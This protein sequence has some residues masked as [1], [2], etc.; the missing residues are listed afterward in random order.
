[1]G[2]MKQTSSDR[3]KFFVSGVCCAAEE[4][5]VR[6]RLDSLIGDESYTFNSITC[7]L[8]LPASVDEYKV[9][10]HLRGAGFVTRRKEDLQEEA[11]FWQRHTDAITTVAATILAGLGLVL[12]QLDG[13]GTVSNSLLLVAIMVG[14]WK[15]FIKAFKAAKSFSLDMNF[16]MTIAVL[17][18]ILIGKWG[19]GAAV[20]VL[21]ALSLALESYSAS[22]TR[23]AIQSLMKLSPSQAS[24][25][26]DGKEKI[27][28]AKEISPGETIIVRPGECVALDGI[29]IDGSSS[30][31]QSPIT[32]EAIP[33]AKDMGATV[34]AGSINERGLL[35]V[36]VSRHYD[37]TTLARIIH[38][39]ENAQL[40]RAPVQT[41][42]DKFARIYTPMVLGI[43]ILVAIVP[44]L[45]YQGPFVEW[46]YR[47]L[48]LLVIACPC[49]LVISTPIT[50]VS[51]ITNAARH[52]ILIKGGKHIESLSSLEAIAF[53][54]TG[55]L[56]EGKSKITDVVPLNS[57]PRER[58]IELLAAIENRSEHHLASAVLEEAER[59]S[60]SYA[61]IRVDD[62]EAIPGLGVRAT[63]AGEDYYLGNHQ[64]CEDRN[65]CSPIVE[66]TLEDLSRDGKTAVVLGREKEAIAI[67]AIRDRTRQQSRNV[68]NTLRDIGIRHMVM[69][70]G[71]HE[72]AAKQLAQE[73][74]IK[75]YTA[76]LLPE[77]KVDAVED[78][79]VRYGNVAMVGD[80]IND[81]PALAA[82]S[83]GI[84]MGGNGTDAALETADVVLMSDDL[85]R[86][87]LLL[88]LCRKAMS[89]IKQN[90]A[91]ALLLKLI[92]LIL[93]ISGFATLWM[94]VLADDGAA[95]VVILNGLRALSMKEYT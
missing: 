60:I 95:L 16:L 62:F 77:R 56:T 7:E 88:R 39:V 57:F 73:V 81:V 93:S 2:S 6:K 66:Q 84:A 78:L 72:E 21:F 19:E 20:I 55:T 30:V 46:F 29:V 44:P 69:L 14:G 90:I 52:G 34:F 79:K 71:D 41:F 28:P 33:V 32:G 43:A 70:S 63:I 15:V 5:Q 9:A 68:I 47:A 76:G 53:D 4:A 48:V 18:A 51:A 85:S 58:I 64:L 82:S 87:P 3:R 1:M 10:K 92:F 8:S 75:E 86:L 45:L 26:R 37:D 59:H 83:A 50:I 17:G 42:V 23:R 49:A 67:M 89:I 12:E 11:T 35:R 94:A 80:G 24:V 22:R 13:S 38:L 54:K 65:Y 25:F 40:K 36:E 61:H 31:N 74:G 91:I 27:V